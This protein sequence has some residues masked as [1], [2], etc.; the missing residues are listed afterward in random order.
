MD[1]KSFK[2]RLNMLSGG[3]NKNGQK[4]LKGA[5]KKQISKMKK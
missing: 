3:F 4:S 2:N 1:S 5:I